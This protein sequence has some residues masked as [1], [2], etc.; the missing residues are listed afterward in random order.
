MHPN[1]DP[2]VSNHVFCSMF[3]WTQ[4]GNTIFTYLTRKFL[5]IAWW[6]SLSLF[7]QKLVDKCNSYLAIKNDKIYFNSQGI[8][9]HDTAFTKQWINL[10]FNIM[11]NAIPV[12]IKDFL[13]IQ[14]IGLQLVEPHNHCTKAAERAIQTFKNHLIE[15]LSTISHD[16][17][18]HFFINFFCNH[19]IH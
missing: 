14:S 4:R 11:D 7:P 16:F 6:A 2:D 17:L 15:R 5:P 3:A 12:A 8:F 1:P 18:L 9:D 13:E 19:S 10:T